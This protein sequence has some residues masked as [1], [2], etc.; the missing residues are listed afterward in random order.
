M[1]VFTGIITPSL[2]PDAGDPVAPLC[3]APAGLQSGPAQT[4]S[5]NTFVTNGGVMLGMPGTFYLED[6]INTAGREPEPEPSLPARVLPRSVAAP[7][8][9]WRS[10]K[11][12]MGINGAQIEAE[13][14]SWTCATP[15]PP[16]CTQTTEVTFTPA[17]T[18]GEITPTQHACIQVCTNAR[19]HHVD[20]GWP[21][22]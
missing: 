11:L 2:G 19:E 8:V 20:Q 6:Y 22:C 9:I 21:G 14:T 16:A 3:A 4:L 18:A 13:I 1:V 12:A 10:A 15:P 7:T 17:I 5:M